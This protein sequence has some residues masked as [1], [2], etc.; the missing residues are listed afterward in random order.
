LTVISDKKTGVSSGGVGSLIDY[1]NPDITSAQDYYPFGMTMPGRFPLGGAPYY[2]YTFNGKENDWEA[3][4]WQN[5]QDYG[6]RVYD[7]R[8]GRFLSVDPLHKNFPYYTPYQFS[9]NDP[10]TNIDLDGGEKKHYL[11]SWDQNHKNA[12]LTYSHD[13]DFT[14]TKTSWT[15]TSTN[16]FKTTTTTTKNPRVEYVVHGDVQIPLSADGMFPDETRTVTWTFESAEKMFGYEKSRREAQAKGPKCWCKPYNWSYAASDQHWDIAFDQAMMYSIEAQAT[17]TIYYPNVFRGAVSKVSKVLFQGNSKNLI[18]NT[19]FTGKIAI[20]DGVLEVTIDM[21]E[22][23][24]PTAER[25]TTYKSLIAKAETLAKENGLETVK[26]IGFPLNKSKS[27]IPFKEAGY[28][29]YQDPSPW[30][31]FP[32]IRTKKIK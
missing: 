25:Y 16:W 4:G 30:G 7:P 15:P 3:K 5:Q 21:I 22:K 19:D 20:Q 11:L 10:I 2:K 13:E 23:I 32:T 28:T 9:G 14:E 12:T 26:F 1:Y 18:P 6:M 27:E 8:L 29:I 31:Y 24:K 17:K